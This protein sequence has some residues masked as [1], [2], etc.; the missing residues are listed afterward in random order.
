MPFRVRQWPVSPD[1]RG[2]LY[3]FVGWNWGQVVSWK[4]IASSVDATGPYEFLNDGLILPSFSD[5]GIETLWLQEVADS[6]GTVVR[7]LKVGFF[8]PILMPPITI[9]WGI[10]ID[11]PSVP[12]GATGSSELFFPD[13]IQEFGP[14]EMFNGPDPVE[15]IPNGVLITPA[16]WNLETT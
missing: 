10:Q 2:S 15:D 7:L 5:D 3:S 9:S 8:P 13:A 6:G 4:W 16:I 14:F 1:P 11:V 12:T